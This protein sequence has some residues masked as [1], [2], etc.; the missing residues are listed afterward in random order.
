V[1][2]PEAARWMKGVER[3]G[4]PWTFGLRPP[5]VEGFLTERGYTLVADESTAAAGDPFFE[6]QGRRDR[7]SGLYRIVVAHREPSCR[8]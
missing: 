2:F 7:G 1:S 4:E 8:R 5:D 3:V 6:A